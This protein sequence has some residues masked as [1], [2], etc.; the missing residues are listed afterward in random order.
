MSGIELAWRVS[1]HSGGGS[2][3]EVA[4]WRK[5]SH[6][7]G[8]SCVE[9][10]A[11]ERM[12]VRDTKDRSGPTLDFPMTSWANFIGQVKAGKFDR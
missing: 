8:G 2:C 12:Y 9:V 6:S 4:L 5:S 7:G 10:G 3:V 11:G 1:S